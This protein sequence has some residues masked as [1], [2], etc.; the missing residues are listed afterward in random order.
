[1][2]RP[3]GLGI[4]QDNMGLHARILANWGRVFREAIGGNSGVI[5]VVNSGG[6][7][8]WRVTP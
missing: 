6:P 5:S 8:M 2:A 3:L 7:M 1:M 4:V